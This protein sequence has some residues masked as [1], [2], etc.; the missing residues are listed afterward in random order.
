LEQPNEKQLT[1]TVQASPATTPE[2]VV[3]LGHARQ[4][5]LV[6]AQAP[7][8]AGR[9]VF[10]INQAELA[11]GIS[12][13]TLFNA[14]RQP[15]CE[16][17][18]FRQPRQQLVV[19]AQTDKRQ[20]TG[21]E[22]VSLQLK[23]AG[24]AGQAVPANLSVAVYRLDSLSADATPDFNSYVWL[25]SDLK[26][27]VEQPEYYLMAT[28]PE[29]AEATDN[30]MLTQGWSRFSW[31]QVLA[32]APPRF[33]FPLELRGHLVRGL[34]RHRDTGR[35]AAG[36]TT[37]LASPNRVARVYNAISAEDGGVQFEVN[38][39]YGPRDIILQANTQQDSTYSFEIF[40]P[41]SQRFARALP[42]RLPAF[43][44]SFR[45]EVAR[46]HLQTQLQNAYARQQQTQYRI[47]APDTLAF[48]GQPDERYRLDDFTRFKVME[49]VLREYVTGVKVRIRK[50][51]FQF[52][53]DDRV[54]RTLFTSPPL[55]LL[56][57][58]PVFQTNK[59]M[60]MDPLRIQKLEVVT[61]RFMQG[62]LLYNGIMSFTTYKGNLEGFQLDPKA[63]VQEYEGLLP[64][65]E[66]YAPRYDTPQEKASRLPDLRNLLYWNPNVNTTTA[67]GEALSFYTSN[68]RG[69]YRVVVQG[70]TAAGIAG[71]GSFTF[72][73]N[74]VL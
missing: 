37:Y 31:K 74:P 1:I 72:E 3:L 67:P 16:R 54:N 9:V 6:S 43:S 20:Y 26:G 17:L 33:E 58:V 38:D 48:Y 25:T 5:L 15:L 55:V 49:E 32:A 22:K 39:L 42:G 44:A 40:N 47:P 53:V 29:V 45:A 70:L 52:T 23:T 41:F 57:G 18:Y 28:G 4:Q 61:S 64:L 56:D 7:L 50:D 73:V 65:R 60:A 51:G 21:R 30:L 62:R 11:E 68:L 34:V 59:L 27:H 63:L 69:R 14:R 36:L 12:H 13:F 2:T 66:F 71:T 19:T 10:T 35:P 8:V 24:P 46:R